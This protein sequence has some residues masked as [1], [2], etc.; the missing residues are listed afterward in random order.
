MKIQQVAVQIYTVRD[1]LKTPKDIVASLKKIRAIG[2][3]AVELIGLPLV[4]DAELKQILDGEG[5]VC[6]GNHEDY[7][8]LREDPSAVADHLDRLCCKYT[9]CSCSAS[10]DF[11]NAISVELFISELNRAGKTL[12]ERGKALCYHNH[13]IEFFHLRNRPILE[14]IYETTNPRHLQGELDTYWVQH[15]GGDPADWCRRLKGRL[16][17]LHMKDY[18]FSIEN[19]PCFA[20]IGYGNF[21]WKEILAAAESSGCEWFIVEQDTCP[22]DPFDS[23]K[24]SFD[25]IRTKL[26]V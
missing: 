12:A 20:E 10:V 5:L 24:M 2:Y 26:A 15:G 19:K 7:N 18:G 6:C 16:P 13:S 8:A 17:L 9:A 14:I 11:N 22:G 4:N 23:L 1:H 3:Q 21:S 25:Y